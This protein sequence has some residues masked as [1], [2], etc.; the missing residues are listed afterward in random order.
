LPEKGQNSGSG[1]DSVMHVQRVSRMRL[2]TG[3][4]I[5]EM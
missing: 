2:L 1:T 3:L 4:I 5:P